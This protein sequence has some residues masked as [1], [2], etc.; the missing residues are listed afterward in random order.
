MR[1]MTN[2]ER[3][4]VLAGLEMNVVSEEG[5]VVNFEGTSFTG[6]LIGN[7]E[8]FDT[9]GFYHFLVTNDTLYKCYYNYKELEL[10]EIDYTNPMAVEE[11]HFEDYI[12]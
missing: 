5:F 6:S 9:E 3:T 1:K 2:E 8:C 7:D 4:M 10:D 11:V 12:D